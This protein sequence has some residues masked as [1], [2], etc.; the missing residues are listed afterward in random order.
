MEERLSEWLSG[1]ISLFDKGAESIPS[2]EEQ[3]ARYVLQ[4]IA[5]ELIE[6]REAFTEGELEH[7]LRK[8]T[9]RHFE[10]LE[11]ILR[12]EPEIVESEIDR[13]LT[14]RVLS[15]M[16]NVV[17]R[18]VNLS[19]LPP[20]KIASDQTAKYVREAA[21]A[22]FWGLFQASAAMS[23]VALEQA[24]KEVL[25]RQ[26]IEDYVSFK[27]LRKEAERK[28]ILDPVTGPAACQIAKDANRV[29]HHRPTDPNSALEILARSRGLIVQIYAA[30]S[31]K[32]R[33][34]GAS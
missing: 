10:P 20:A 27:T 19:K 7:A 15:D 5:E 22:Y 32:S 31:G 1:Q 9:E 3:K 26:G 29:I 33:I 34:S 11:H 23:R 6:A 13:L 12:D 24:L 28:G 30:A 16:R 14:T 25:G 17:D 21:R 2:S 18:V 4:R 8:V